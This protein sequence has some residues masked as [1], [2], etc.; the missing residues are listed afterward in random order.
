V[1]LSLSLEILIFLILYF[2][3]CIDSTK[4]YYH[5]NSQNSSFHIIHLFSYFLIFD[6]SLRYTIYFF[7]FR[8]LQWIEHFKVYFDFS[9]F[10][11]HMDFQHTENNYFIG[12]F[13][14]Y[15]INFTNW[16]SFSILYTF[17][18]FQDIFYLLMN[19]YF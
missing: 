11:F 19:N 10:V 17:P 9:F 5:G 8:S 14:L 16:F 6:S 1:S 12:F 18:Y 7:W 15:W 4:I 13:K 3:Y 2:H